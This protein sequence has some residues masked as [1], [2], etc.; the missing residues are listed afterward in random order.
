MCGRT[1]SLEEAEEDAAEMEGE[2]EEDEG[3]AAGAAVTPALVCACFDL[4]LFFLPSTAS[5]FP[6]PTAADASAGVGAGDA[7]R[8]DASSPLGREEGGCRPDEDEGGVTS[9]VITAPSTQLYLTPRR[10]RPPPS[11]LDDADAAAAE[12]ARLRPP[13][14]ALDGAV[15]ARV[16]VGGSRGAFDITAG[17][18]FTPLA[19]DGWRRG[20]TRVGRVALRVTTPYEGGS[21]VPGSGGGPWEV[22]VRCGMSPLLATTRACSSR[23]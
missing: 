20:D 18:A 4:L 10:A 8:L 17:P 14:D 15:E 13:L 6:C 1:S 7:E 19:G 2:E 11:S 16:A 12:D 5:P 22:M 23:W 21:E 3:A 9:S